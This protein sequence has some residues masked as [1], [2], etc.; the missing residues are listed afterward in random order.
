[1]SRTQAGTILRQK[2]HPGFPDD[3]W[4]LA[5][6]EA[7][8]LETWMIDASEEHLCLVPC[9][10]ADGPLFFQDKAQVLIHV[11]ACA[12]E[13][14][15][16]HRKAL[17]IHD[18]YVPRLLSESQKYPSSL[19][20]AEEALAQR[21]H[22]ELA[23]TAFE[24]GRN[25]LKDACDAQEIVVHRSAL[26]RL[27]AA[28]DALRDSV[29]IYKLPP[30]EVTPLTSELQLL[31]STLT[32]PRVR[33]CIRATTLDLEVL[34]ALA[35]RVLTLLQ[36]FIDIDRFVIVSNGSRVDSDNKS[37]TALSAAY[38]HSLESET[39]CTIVYNGHAVAT[40]KVHISESNAGQI[41]SSGENG[42]FNVILRGQRINIDSDKQDNLTI[43]DADGNIL[44]WTL[45][46]DEWLEFYNKADFLGIE[47]DFWGYSHPTSSEE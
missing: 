33:D 28:I 38:F 18:K 42:P 12:L 14:S 31:Y 23:R 27:D 16:L 24:E 35:T 26:V 4:T 39:P 22:V 20:P 9:T 1:M 15:L 44:P 46:S 41:W 40:I 17:A 7:A 3:D 47:T 43:R 6:D 2:A 36:E 8:R 13:G 32:S 30:R 11:T 29:T 45:T 5:D 10:D 21:S 25:T 37:D 34:E 19:T